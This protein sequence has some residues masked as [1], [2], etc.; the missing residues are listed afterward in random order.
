MEEKQLEIREKLSEFVLLEAAS[1]CSLAF[2]MTNSHD[3]VI[4]EIVVQIVVVTSVPRPHWNFGGTE[5]TGY[6]V[7]LIRLQNIANL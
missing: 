3:T 5:W 2:L 1:S 4:Y 7:G 6:A